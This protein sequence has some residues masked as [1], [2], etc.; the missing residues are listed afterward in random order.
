MTQYALIRKIATG[1]MAEVFLAHGPNKKPVVLKKIL[2]HLSSNS[3]YLRMFQN[4]V[5]ILARLRHRNIVNILEIK[6]DTIVMEYLDGQDWRVLSQHSVPLPI[7]ASLFLKAL[8]VLSF[9]HRK[10]IVHR[11]ISPQNWMLTSDGEVKLLDF[12]ISKIEHESSHTVTGVLKGKY[13]YMSPEQAA[14]EKIS[15]QSDIFSMGVIF[16]ELCVGK[17]LFK[18]SNDLLTLKNISE[19]QVSIPETLPKQLANI[20]RRALEKDPEKRFETCE[21]FRQELVKYVADSGQVASEAEI[22][23][24]L[25]ALPRTHHAVLF[26]ST[27]IESSKSRFWGIGVIALLFDLLG[28]GW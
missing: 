3:E 21:D 1:G 13:G 12:G 2:P 15:F 11:D 10:K 27:Q 9:V 5:G 25:K 17:R 6:K 22:V 8:K 24:W 19:C 7:V 16:F 23:Q 20:L 26:E 18:R 28:L 4:E 14:G